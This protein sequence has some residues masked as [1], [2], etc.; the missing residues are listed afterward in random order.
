MP[1]LKCDLGETQKGNLIISDALFTSRSL[2]FIIPRTRFA[3]F[4]FHTHVIKIGRQKHP[5]HPSRTLFPTVLV[6]TGKQLN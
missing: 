2:H 1:M 3:R 6:E 5:P 4:F